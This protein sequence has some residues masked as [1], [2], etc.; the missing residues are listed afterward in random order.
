M[1]CRYCNTDKK[2]LVKREQ[3]CYHISPVRR[4]ILLI[5]WENLNVPQQ[6]AL[7]DQVSEYIE[8]R[9]FRI[10]LFFCQAGGVKR[11]GSGYG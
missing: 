5:A 8:A 11:K 10:G 2:A 1:A 7:A 9:S 6:V 4:M 3:V